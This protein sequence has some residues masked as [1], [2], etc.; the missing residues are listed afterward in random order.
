M[1]G[2]DVVVFTH[3][4]EMI[5]KLPMAAVASLTF[6]VHS[7]ALRL[8]SRHHGQNWRGSESL[9]VSF[10]QVL[11][12]Y[13]VVLWGVQLDG[14]FGLKSCRHFFCILR[15]EAKELRKRQELLFRHPLIASPTSAQKSAN[16]NCGARTTCRQRIA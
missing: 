3:L 14:S 16:G 11:E 1:A 6:L 7:Y 13:R 15:C 4:A 5:L 2:I 8:Q 12:R 9:T 10:R